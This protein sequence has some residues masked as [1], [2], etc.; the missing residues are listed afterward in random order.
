MSDQT[1]YK[2]IQTAPQDNV[3]IIPHPGGLTKGT[4][5]SE[6]LVLAEDIPMGHKAALVD[7]PKGSAVIRYGQVIGYTNTD[8]VKGSWLN[9]INI[10]MP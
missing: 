9:E 10:T 1:I 7:M 3:G 2:I 6:D 8:V 5:V 4:I